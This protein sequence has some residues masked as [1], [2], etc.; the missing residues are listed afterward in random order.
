MFR[1]ARYWI[2]GALLALCSGAVLSDDIRNYYEEPG[3]TPFKSATDSLNESINVFSGALEIS[4]A[5]LTLP[6]NGG[7]DLQVTR[8]YN[9]HSNVRR[10]PNYMSVYGVGWTMHFGRIVK[11]ALAG[12]CPTG[13]TTNYNSSLELPDGSRHLLVLD[14]DGSG[15][16]ITHNNWRAHCGISAEG[17]H[18]MLVTS[19]DGTR[20]T[21]DQFMAITLGEVTETSWFTS[22]IED[23]HGNTLNITYKADALGYQYL[24]SISSSDGRLVEFIYDTDAD[25]CF[26]LHQMQS[27]DQVW[28]YTYEIVSGL[29]PAD[30]GVC[31]H[32]LTQVT[33]PD[34]RTWKYSY[35][36]PSNS[37][38]AYSLKSITYPYGGTVTY[39]YDEVVFGIVIGVPY[40]TAPLPE[41]TTVV[42]TKTTAGPDVTPGTWTYKYEP[43]S[44]P[45][46]TSPIL[47]G[48]GYV[49]DTG[50]N[51]KTTVIT[52]TAINVYEHIGSYAV[53]VHYGTEVCHFWLKDYQMG[54][55]RKQQTYALSALDDDDLSNDTPIE[56]IQ[57]Y[58]APRQIS[59]QPYWHGGPS[60]RIE[61]EGTF[62]PQLTK[63]TIWRDDPELKHS[64]RTEYSNYDHYGNA[65]TTIEYVRFGDARTT[66]R[67][68]Y[69][70]PNLWI[71]GRVATETVEDVEL[72]SSND[73]ACTALPQDMTTTRSYDPNTGDLLS[74][75][76][77]GILTQYTYYPT[78][79]LQTKTDARGNKTTY[80]QYYRGT[81][82][83]EVFADNT[84]G[85]ASRTITR[86]VNPTGTVASL[87]NGRGYT[88]GFSYD[89]LNR[90]TGID[91][92]LNADVSIN[93]SDPYLPRGRKLIRKD[94]NDPGHTYQQVDYFDGFG[95]TVQT[96]RIGN[97]ETITVTHRYDALGQTVF[98]SNPNSALGTT[99]QFDTL[100]RTVEIRHPDATFRQYQYAQAD[101]IVSETDERGK[102]STHYYRAF[103]SPGNDQVQIQLDQSADDSGSRPIRTLSFYNHLNQMIVGLQGEPSGDITYGYPRYYAYNN[104][105][106][107]EKEQ[108]PEFGAR[109]YTHDAIGNIA[110]VK[111]INSSVESGLT[112][113]EYDGLN[114]LTYTDYP[115]DTADV[116]RTYDANDNLINIQKGDTHWHY[117]YDA[118]DNL[119]EETLNLMQESGTTRTYSF[120]YLYNTLDALA[121]ITYPD[122]T[123]IG[124]NPDAFGRATEVTDFASK[125]EFHPNGHLKTVTLAN[126][127]TL[128]ITLNTRLFPE[129][130]SV[131]GFSG[132]QVDLSYTYDGVGNVTRILDGVQSSRSVDGLKY[133]GINRLIEANGSWGSG[134]FSYDVTNNLLSQT[135]SGQTLNYYYNG[136]WLSALS[137][138]VAR[139]YTHDIFGNIHSNGSQT[140]FYDWASQ[141]VEISDTNTGAHTSYRYDGHGQRTIEIDEQTGQRRYTLYNRAGQLLYE[142]DL[143]NCRYTDYIRL[144]GFL[145][146]RQERTDDESDSDHDGL[147]D[148]KEDIYGLN[149]YEP[150]GTNDTDEDGLTDAQ[151]IALG[152]D[153][154]NPD[155]DGDGV[156]DGAEVTAGTDPLSPRLWSAAV[157]GIVFG[158]VALA[159]DGT[160]YV[161]TIAGTVYAFNPDGSVRWTYTTGGSLLGAPTVDSSGTVYVHNASYLYALNANGTLRWRSLVLDSGRDSPALA[162]DGTIY[163]GW[164]VSSAPDAYSLYTFKA[165]N[166][167]GTE[168]WTFK[169]IDGWAT[170]A[171]IGTDGTIYVAA[172]A[173]GLI[174]SVAYLYAIS[175]EGQFQ[176]R[177]AL[178]A[179]DV[180]SSPAIGSDGTIYIGAYDRRLYA[181]NSDGSLRWS[182]LTGAIIKSSPI[183]GADSTVYV[184]SNDGYLYALNPD[185][186]LKWRTFVFGT[187]PGAPAIGADGTIYVGSGDDQIY[188]LAPEN[189]AIRWH[190]AF[191]GDVAASPVIGANGTVYIGS[192]DKSVYAFTGVSGDT[193]NSIWP[194]FQR[195]AQH[196]GRM[197]ETTL[198]P[199]GD[200]DG[201]GMSNSFEQQHGLDPLDPSDASQ[202]GDN[203]GFSNLQEFQ[204][205][206]DPSDPDSDDDGL[207]DGDEILTFHT[208]PL[209]ADSDGD[210][211]SDCRELYQLGTL[212]TEA[213]TDRDGLQDGAE[214]TQSLNPL[215]ALHDADGDTYNDAQEVLSGTD[216]HNAASHPLDGQLAWTRSLGSAGIPG[217]LALGKNS[218]VYAQADGEALWA[219]NPDGTV[220]W[221]YP[222]N[223]SGT[224]APT[225]DA[226]NRVL[227]VQEDASLSALDP[228]S[229]LLWRYLVTQSTIGTSLALAADGTGY[230]GQTSG[231]II[232]LNADGTLSWSYQTEG[233]ITSSPAVA[234]DG[235]VYLG[236]QDQSLY[237]LNADGTLKWRYTTDGEIHASPAIDAQGTIYVGATDSYLYAIDADGNLRWRYATDGEIHASPAIGPD[238]T[239]Y[240]GA[241]DYDF[242]ALNADGTLK[243]RAVG[244]GSSVS[245]ALAADGTVYVGAG[246]D[247][248]AFYQDGTL[249]WQFQTQG[250]IRSAPMVGDNGLIYIGSEDA[251][252]YALVDANGGPSAGP[253]PMFQHDAQHTGRQTLDLALQNR[254]QTL[255][256]KATPR[257]LVHLKDQTATNLWF[258]RDGTD[259]L[260]QPRHTDGALRLS[261][262]FAVETKDRL[263]LEDQE[264]AHLAPQAVDRLL[265]VMHDDSGYTQEPW[266][267]IVGDKVSDL[268]RAKSYRQDDPEQVTVL[269]Q[270]LQL[271]AADVPNSGYRL[272]GYLEAPVSGAYT[273]SLPTVSDLGEG[274]VAFYLSESEN[275]VS[276]RV[277]SLASESNPTGKPV[278]LQAGQRYYF[279][280]YRK[281]GAE[282]PAS[283]T[284][285]SMYWQRSGA[286][287]EVI[288]LDALHLHGQALTART[289]RTQRNQPALS[290]AVKAVMADA[291]SGLSQRSL[292][293]QP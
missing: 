285:I 172:N 108:Q 25:G 40:S 56:V 254:Q 77:Y 223:S 159:M 102:T 230:F 196:H 137:G 235:T 218:T 181:I 85:G 17:L 213:D 53:E 78:G 243:W 112:V 33:L 99:S 229:T 59:E 216:P 86:E 128:D 122:G 176:W 83:R 97:A 251:K 46:S 116:L 94:P 70:D 93:W 163:M 277:V 125:V 187:I 47:T 36:P 260:V 23:I 49:F 71:I 42:A 13:G 165:F 264:G 121:E 22:K 161:G 284:A 283:A 58:W 205:G 227:A 95:R 262:W 105:G 124:Y 274:S 43:Q 257:A 55:L 107:L 247:L 271:P 109:Y 152:T 3:I 151:E 249:K 67:S 136:M 217:P 282:I 64:L 160:M 88:V 189:G 164:Q 147:T 20:Y 289:S 73:S 210:T 37:P 155:S 261:G 239:I 195:D 130:L 241:N 34:G 48:C 123:V 7:L 145:L 252:V 6:G 113:Y 69:N 74:E 198:P 24:D 82:Q 220:Q 184:G 68:Y 150:D 211:L 52:P 50:K 141:L 66:Q 120:Q 291:W 134:S 84:N 142:Q 281:V 278:T 144:G 16:Y 245:P 30:G 35:Y 87:T 12:I 14:T 263:Y 101:S 1:Q 180:Q 194:M 228:D 179:T 182:Y 100:G 193:S 51:D 178:G 76:R 28:E 96:D 31:G 258:S 290:P 215:D 253:W 81:A 15:D 89:I 129:H 191:S 118:N 268:F 115:D 269:Q 293:G 162:S 267:A 222:A 4:H 110:S 203:D 175:A 204:A 185:G 265:E 5:D 60:W 41:P 273:F 75:D 158:E 38:G 149:P 192:F 29:N 234:V 63:R 226:E 287:A 197:G 240:V 90:V 270:A 170:S 32:N 104:H 62:V 292:E 117:A 256:V 208:N 236:S 173:A 174:D 18:F 167:D 288:P 200:S 238:G 266:R 26:K 250:E 92:P 98:V 183:L 272:S 8:Y 169:G 103:G 275:P 157:D 246:N 214:V 139:S 202:D 219:L 148:C 212:P 190:F 10:Y 201:D 233:P 79:D 135:L 61:D 11:P 280:W 111:T 106:F 65:G 237:A 39:T 131:T 242:Y 255:A 259:L 171:A 279:E 127:Q 114:R 21:M 286:A 138:T 143:S 119:L 126:N 80:S 168:R 146:A 209:L 91:Y 199:D 44:I 72:C 225:V 188:A 221:S 140:F 206:T 224:Q 133:D 156:L 232:A 177:F 54:L 231:T 27:G 166:P 207:S 153:L 132:T 19:P 244:M 45:W 154:A 186:S 248:Y 57:Q 276:L 2:L 9:H